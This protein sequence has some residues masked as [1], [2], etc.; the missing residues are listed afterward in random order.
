VFLTTATKCSSRA[1]TFDVEGAEE[2]EEFEVD[3]EEAACSSREVRCSKAAAAMT[4]E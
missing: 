3:R 4:E 1:A 2:P